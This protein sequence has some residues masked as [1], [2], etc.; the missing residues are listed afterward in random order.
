M[1]LLIQDLGINDAIRL[2]DTLLSAEPIDSDMR[3][4]AKYQFIDFVVVALV[5]GISVKI[6]N[7]GD[8]AG[9]M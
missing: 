6:L 7:D 4:L 5:Q 9:C 8:F 2:W 3:G 1:L